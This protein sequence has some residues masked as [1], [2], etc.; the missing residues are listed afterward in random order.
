MRISLEEIREIRE[1]QAILFESLCY[2]DDYCKEHNLEYFLANGSLLGAAKYQRF[3]PW[4]DDVDVL[5]PREDYDKLMQHTKINNQKYKLLCSEQVSE[6]RMPYAKLS[7]ESTLIK[8]RDYNFGLDFGLSIDIFPID[9]W[10]SL[11]PMAR[12]QAIIGEI[13]KRLLVAAIGGDF[14]T[15]KTGIKKIILFLIWFAGKNFGYQK[16]LKRIKK[17]ME[18]AKQRKKRY[19]GCIA[20]TCHLDKEVFSAAVF[21]KKQYLFFEGRKFPVPANYEK[22]L[23]NLYGN[24]KEELKPE[25][26]HSNHDIKVWW[27][28]ER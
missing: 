12:V 26:Q 23:N 1:I 25:D 13:Y 28:D 24:W 3:I 6:W 20:W 15:S 14:S 16:I 19:I 27:K 2:F 5:M 18:V 9:N 4:D 11:Y 17:R 8:E 22:Y 10:S 7:C 21:E